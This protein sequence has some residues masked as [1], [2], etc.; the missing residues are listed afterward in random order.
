M[1]LLPDDFEVPTVL[2]VPPFHLEP[3]GPQHNEAD[4][5]AWSSSIEHIRTSPGWGGGDWPPVEGMT[6]DQNRGDLV[7][8]AKDFAERTGFT[9]TVLDA[10]TRDVIGCLY[11]YPHRD[12]TPGTRV[13]SWVRVSHAHLDKALYEVVSDWLAAWPLEDVGYAER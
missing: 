3:L 13:R 6:L 1:P 2:D 10:E 11:I 12:G 4:H 7:E 9:Y 8:H 5:A